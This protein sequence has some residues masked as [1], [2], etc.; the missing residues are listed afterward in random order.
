MKATQCRLGLAPLNVSTVVF[1]IVT[2]TLDRDARCLYVV[3][4]STGVADRSAV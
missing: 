4:R 1:L 2:L 3:P